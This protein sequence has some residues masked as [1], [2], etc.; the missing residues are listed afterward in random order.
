MAYSSSSNPV[1]KIVSAGFDGGGSIYAYEST[2]THAAVEANG[3]F[4]GCG[5]G[6]PGPNCV[7][8]KPGDLVVAV[9]QAT[10]GTSAITWHRVTSISTSTGWGSL[11]NCTVSAAS[12]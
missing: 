3:F 5:F 8:M 11:L 9:C 1:K 4:T 6:S 7:G 12:S 2:H 10:S